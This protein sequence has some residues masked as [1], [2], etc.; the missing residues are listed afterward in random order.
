MIEDVYFFKDFWGIEIYMSLEVILCRGYLIKV[1][2][3]SL[4]VM[5]IYM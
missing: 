2:I 1:D 5:F 4:G 3:Y